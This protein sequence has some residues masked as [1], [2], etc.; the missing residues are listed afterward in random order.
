MK[1]YIFLDFQWTWWC[2]V[3]MRD[4]VMTGRHILQEMWHMLS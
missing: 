4:N 1:Y 2:L 3:A